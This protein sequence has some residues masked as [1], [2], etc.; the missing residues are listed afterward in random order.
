RILRHPRLHPHRPTNP[1]PQRL[2]RNLRALRDGLLRRRQGLPHP[3]RS[4]LHRSHRPRSR[5]GL[6]LRPH[7]PRRKIQNPPPPHRVLDGR[8]RGSLPR[9]RR[10]PRPRRRLHHPHCHHGPRPPPRRP[11]SH[12]QRHHQTGSRHRPKP[13]LRPRLRFCTFRRLPFVVIPQ[14]SGGIC[15]YFHHPQQIPPPKLRRSP[16]HA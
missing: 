13:R 12:R 2:R 6:Q 1:H 3:I 9:T 5:Q 14:R 10:P 11:Q 7:L 8:T 4:A 16:R 15:C